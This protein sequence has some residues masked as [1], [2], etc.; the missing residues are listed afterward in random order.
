MVQG[1]VDPGPTEHA[2]PVA[3]DKRV[4]DCG[5]Y[6]PGQGVVDD[7]PEGGVAVVFYRS[8]LTSA[9]TDPVDA[10]IAGF[11]AKGLAAYGVF[12]PS[13]KGEAAG[14]VAETLD[15][16]KPRAVVNATAFSAKGAD[17][18][19]PLD[20]PGVPVFEVALST[21]RRRDWAG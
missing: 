3:G 14:W 15:R 9:D 2:G 13:L 17:G 12:A 19:S 6:L 21:A 7:A 16:L 5:L 20:V 11:E 1:G 10:L 8:Y 18:T 4:P